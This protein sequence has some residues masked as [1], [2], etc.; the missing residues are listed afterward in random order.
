MSAEADGS[1]AKR[2]RETEETV[3]A[4]NAKEARVE[5]GSDE[6]GCDAVDRDAD[7]VD[8]VVVANEPAAPVEDAPATATE[9]EAFVAQ[10]PAEEPKEEPADKPE[11]DVTLEDA[12]DSL[13]PKV[14]KRLAVLYASNLIA[15]H[16]ME[17]KTLHQLG[18]FTPA[19]AVEIIDGISEESLKGA[20]DKNEFLTTLMRGIKNPAQVKAMTRAPRGGAGGRNGA[21]AP[22][23]AVIDALQRVY[24]LGVVS[25][26]QIDEKMLDHLAR[27]PEPLAVAS[28]DELGKADVAGIRNVNGYLKSICR[29][30]EP[31]VRGCSGKFGVPY[32]AGG[33]L[34]GGGGGQSQNGR[35]NRGGG[36]QTGGARPAPPEAFFEIQRRFQMVRPCAFPES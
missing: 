4:P 1:G 6:P 13:A 15:E 36:F 29:R 19:Q 28:V 11:P 31:E 26:N 27:M 10:E 32:G 16:E 30:H 9:T 25:S 3:D 2:E 33:D 34:A 8:D 20:E 7:A 23:Q 21:G 18:E 35:D 22:S 5:T 17:A 24:A 12:L 14:T